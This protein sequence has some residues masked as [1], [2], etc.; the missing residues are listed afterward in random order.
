MQ[1]KLYAL[2]KSKDINMTQEE[3]AKLLDMDVST[4][5]RKEGSKSPFSQDDMFAIASHFDMNIHDIFLPRK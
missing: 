3:M 2:R 5:R 4:Y 1:Y